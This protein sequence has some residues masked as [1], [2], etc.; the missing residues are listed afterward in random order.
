MGDH[1]DESIKDYLGETRPLPQGL[2]QK[3]KD[4]VPGTKRGVAN[5]PHCGKPISSPKKPS[6]GDWNLLWLAAMAFFFGLSFVFQSYF[7]QCLVATL[8]CA[9]KWIIERRAR[10]TQI[11]IYKALTEE[12]GEALSHRLHRHTTRL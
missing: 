3:A 7:Y 9:F 1:L 12:S 4:L 11:L 8:I 2:V 5:C 10:K 6:A